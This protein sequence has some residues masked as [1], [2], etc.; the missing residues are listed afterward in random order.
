MDGKQTFPFRLEDVWE[1]DR[2]NPYVRAIQASRK[3]PGTIGKMGGNLSAHFVLWRIVKEMGLN[4][5][6]VERMTFDQMME[7]VGYIDM[8]HDYRDAWDEY[9]KMQRTAVSNGSK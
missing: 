6:E 7:A 4:L 9:Y 5:S 1:L 3:G 8:T 2:S